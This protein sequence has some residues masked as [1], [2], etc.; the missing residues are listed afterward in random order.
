MNTVRSLAET[1]LTSLINDMNINGEGNTP[2]L[3]ELAFLLHAGAKLGLTGES[4]GNWNLR[5]DTKNEVKYSMAHTL[6]NLLQYVSM[7]ASLITLRIQ[8]SLVWQG[9]SCSWP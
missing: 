9:L 8:R 2:S 6:D 3:E 5:K 1:A 7:V 4:L